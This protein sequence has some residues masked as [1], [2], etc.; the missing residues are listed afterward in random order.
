MIRYSFRY[1]YLGVLMTGLCGLPLKISRI[2]CARG[3]RRRQDRWHRCF[4]LRRCVCRRGAR[5]FRTA[6]CRS[7]R[8]RTRTPESFASGFS[9]RCRQYRSRGPCTCSR[10][11]CKYFRRGTSREPWTPRADRPAHQA[12]HGSS[13]P[14]SCT[15][16]RSSSRRCTPPWVRTLVGRRCRL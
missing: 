13:R 5:S 3:R 7:I 8:P 14:R 4:R 6:R 15:V 12:G 11:A 2:G 9:R 10:W 1:A 16:D